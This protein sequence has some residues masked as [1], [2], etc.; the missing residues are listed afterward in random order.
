[1]TVPFG[2]SDDLASMLEGLSRMLRKGAHQGPV[3]WD[4][5]LATARAGIGDHEPL[6]PSQRDTVDQAADIADVWLDATTVFPNTGTRLT[7][8]SRRD[9]LEETFPQWRGVV[10]PVAAGIA[11]AMAG[12]LP[13]SGQLPEAVLDALPP[14]LRD[15]LEQQLESPQFLEM[16][17]QLSA[18]AQGMGANVYG[19][20]FGRALADMGTEVLGTSDIGVPLAGASKP[21]LI[22][23]NIQGFAEGLGVAVSDMLVYTAVREV[24]HQ[25]L[26]ASATWL[27]PQLRAALERFAAGVRIDNDN[28]GR[29]MAEVD[30]SNPEALAA[31]LEGNLFNPE[32]SPDQRIALDVLE[33]LLA[34]IEGWVTT[35]S[36]QA[37]AE[38][39]ASSPAID[40]A[41]RR[42]RAAGGPAEKLFAGLVGLELR[43]IRIREATLLWQRISDEAGT[44][45]RDMLWSHPDL[46]PTSNDLVEGTFTVSSGAD[47]MTELAPELE[48]GQ[49]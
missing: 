47:L 39:I 21:L 12:V 14:G 35:V 34:L 23:S 16:T 37:V 45:A 2:G 6:R 41:L 4:A 26:F 32:P 49:D 19:V 31:L 15:Q 10:E 48:P 29:A 25:R 18:L 20:Q 17:Q 27:G 42:R 1:V 28:V 40:E 43:P 44:A 36:A 11:T 5:A 24:A 46:L 33:T 3:D 13:G 7:A 9:W 30:P 22:I 8:A 38:R